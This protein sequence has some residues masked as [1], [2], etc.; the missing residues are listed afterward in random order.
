MQFFQINV[1]LQ[2]SRNLPNRTQLL[3]RKMYGRRRHVYESVFISFVQEELTRSL[4]PSS[5]RRPSRLQYAPSFLNKELFG[6]EERKLVLVFTAA[7]LLFSVH[8]CGLRSASSTIRPSNAVI[9]L[10]WS[11]M[12]ALPKF[13]ESSDTQSRNLYFIMSRFFNGLKRFYDEKS[14]S[15]SNISFFLTKCYKKPEKKVQYALAMYVHTMY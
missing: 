6:K 15:R 10:C 4:F 1:H 8:A 5:I 13:W 11:K 7:L 3:K 14:N 2:S 9:V 12:K